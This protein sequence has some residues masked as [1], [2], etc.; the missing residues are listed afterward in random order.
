M[1]EQDTRNFQRARNINDLGVLGDPERWGSVA[2]ISIEIIGEDEIQVFSPQLIRVQCQDLVAR[3]WD[4]IVDWKLDGFVNG[5][6]IN[7]CGL[8][9]TIGV[10]QASRAMV[11]DLT[12]ALSGYPSPIGPVAGYGQLPPIS[13]E[14][15]TL[16]FGNNTYRSGTFALPWPLPAS[17]LAARFV[18]AV[19][20]VGPLHIPPHTVSGD[21]FA[22]CSPRALR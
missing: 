13:W 9:I 3:S 16:P 17:A 12:A 15:Q 4:V 8:E 18:L 11:L 10:G 2:P 22:A 19:Q 6:Q 5:D 20:H 1:Q 21:V 14:V 7:R